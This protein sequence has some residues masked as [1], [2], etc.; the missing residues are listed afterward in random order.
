[1]KL[2]KSPTTTNINMERLFPNLSKF[3][4][5][6]KSIKY[7]KLYTLDRTQIILAD[8]HDKV[9][10]IMINNKKKITE[11]EID[12]IIQQ[13]IKT[14][15]SNVEIN[16][17]FKKELIERGANFTEPLKDVILLKKIWVGRDKESIMLP[18]VI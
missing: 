16:R 15:K 13:L 11:A 4:F 5:N 12:L 10:V 7:Y 14:E 3:I 8:I 9:V 17:D 6:Q 18:F 1:M 2:V